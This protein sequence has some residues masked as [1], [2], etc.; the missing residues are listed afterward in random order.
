MI[1]YTQYPI[2]IKKMDGSNL[3]VYIFTDKIY[4][5]LKKNVFA[6]E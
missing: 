6:I 4:F 3:Y 1:L 5:Y 2:V